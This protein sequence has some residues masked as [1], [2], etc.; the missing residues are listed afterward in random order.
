MAAHRYWRVRFSSATGGGDVWL[1]ELEFLAAGTAAVVPPKSHSVSG[2]YSASYPSASLF[3]GAKTSG[4]GWASN[5]ATCWVA[6]DFTNPVDIE[7]AR[8]YNAWQPESSSELPAPGYV[9]LEYSDNKSTWT[10]QSREVYG[11]SNYGADLIVGVNRLP[12]TTK[13]ARYWKLTNVMSRSDVLNLT[14]IELW[15]GTNRVCQ[16]AILTSSIPADY[17]TTATLKTES[18]NVV[19]YNYPTR[20]AFPEFTWDAGAGNTMEVLL[21]RFAGGNEADFIKYFTLSYSTDGVNWTVYYASQRFSLKYPGS[22]VF[23]PMPAPNTLFVPLIETL[24][25]VNTATVDNVAKTVNLTQ[26]NVFPMRAI[27]PITTGQRQYM[28]ITLPTDNDYPWTISI[29]KPDIIDASAKGI[30]DP[31]VYAGI[32]IYKHTSTLSCFG[33]A[34]ASAGPLTIYPG[35]TSGGVLGIAIDTSTGLL[36]FFSSSGKIGWKGTQLTQDNIYLV[37]SR[38]YT[39]N[40]N[41]ATQDRI[42][43]LNFGQ[44]AFVRGL[45]AGYSTGFGFLYEYENTSIYSTGALGP[46]GAFSSV[47]GPDDDGDKFHFSQPSKVV[48]YQQYC[49]RGYIKNRVYTKGTPN[50]PARKKIV[51]FDLATN[52]CVGETVSDVTGLFEFKFLD[53]KLKYVAMA[54]DELGQWEPA[55]TGPITPSIMPLITV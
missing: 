37:I 51:L 5:S 48:Q 25:T 24:G 45:P 52:I 1:S 27:L 49:G 6:V 40:T 18:A 36:T 41:L 34:I 31:G 38:D 50:N 33:S 35:F 54:L 22:T 16:N 10:E 9:F 42:F 2:T 39:A 53:E 15:N 32:T 17:G 28:E 26:D 43:S 47:A 46:D 19:L 7:A 14:R 23:T 29:M 8:I 4:N 55:C 11:G 44:N 3:D 30:N 21:V 12:T 13:Q 20:K